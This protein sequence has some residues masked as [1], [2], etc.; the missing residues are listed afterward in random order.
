[1]ETPPWT[2]QW[3]PS[4]PC[5]A[6]CECSGSGPAPIKPAHKPTEACSAPRSLSKLEQTRRALEGGGAGGG[7]APALAAGG[8]AAGGDGAAL[9][10]V[11]AELAHHTELLARLKADLDAIYRKVRWV[12]ASAG[13]W[14]GCSEAMRAAALHACGPNLAHTWRPGRRLL[15]A[16]TSTCP[17]LLPRDRRGR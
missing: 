10:E 8:G 7:A 11:V 15:S 1:M 14:V 2:Q 3:Q 4:W 9:A 17:R 6:K 16:P 13:K 5:S 12:Q